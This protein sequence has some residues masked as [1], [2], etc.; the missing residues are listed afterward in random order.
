[1]QSINIPA[2]KYRSIVFHSVVTFI[3]QSLMQ[4][5]DLLFCRNLGSEATATIGTSTTLFAW[6]IMIGL[7]VVSSIEYFVPK[8]IG[9]GNEEEARGFFRTGILVSLLVSFACAV[10]L[11][12]FGRYNSV[13][14]TNP[15]IQEPVKLFCSIIAPCYFAVFVVP[16][17]RV[18]LQARGR[19][20]DTTWAFVYAN[21][22]NI[23]L[24]W[25]LV[26][27]HLGIPA[28]GLKGSAWANVISR[29]GLI[30]YVAWRTFN[31]RRTVFRNRPADT[32]YAP[33]AYWNYAKKIIKTGIPTSLHLLFEMG[34]F[35]CV[36]ILA[37]RLTASQNAA[38]SIALTIISFLFMIPLGLSSAA[39]VTMS[40]ALGEGNKE[41]ALY[42][43]RI[44]LKLATIYAIIG[45]LTV[46]SCRTLLMHL[47]TVD[48]ETIRIG[49][50]LL[51]IAAIFQFGDVMQVVLAA[52]LRGV[53]KTKDQP[54]INGIGHWLIGLPI[55]IILAFY[56][57][58]EITGL[59]IG[60]CMG[61]FSVAFGL[62]LRWKKSRLAL[63]GVFKL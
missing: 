60:L 63:M 12:I 2:P 15:A 62:W 34:A 9:A 16:I 3:G 8:S 32:V 6:L 48:A 59:W 7:G 54:V 31:V 57:H 38:H 13:L 26:L 14:G 50:G 41:L 19:P 4:V 52:L 5:V 36:G 55:G 56:F 45:S 29:A 37:S 20:H 58:L 27:G 39:T 1:M 49:K 25:V 22:F 35:V 51:L 24:N 21:I 10:L 40:R 42:L 17:F 46:V 44:T 28:L 47:Y 11:T 61:L 30:T 18:E 43:A 33:I 53:G 23:F